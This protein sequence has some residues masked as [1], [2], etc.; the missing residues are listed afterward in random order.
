MNT[1]RQKALLIIDMQKASFSQGTSKH[2]ADTVVDRINLLSKRFRDAGY[3]VIV[4]Q[5]DGSAQ[6]EYVP[7]SIDWQLLDELEVSKDDFRI[8]KRANDSFYQT[9]LQELLTRLQVHELF[10]TGAATDFCVDSTVQSALVKD[11][12]V[13][14]AED[15]HTAGPRPHVNAEQVVNH[16]NWIWGNLT[17]TKGK[18]IV[19]KTTAIIESLG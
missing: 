15:G 7:G 5:H 6:N 12:D 13:V 2:N 8:D 1:N 3:P 19:K 4:I 18:V 10:I 9:S 11:Y 14:I 17:P 16:Y